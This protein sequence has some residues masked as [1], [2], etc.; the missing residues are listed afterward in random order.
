MS[1]LFEEWF[2]KMFPKKVPQTGLIVKPPTPEDYIAGASPVTGL[3][4][5]RLPNGIWTPYRPTAEAQY[6]QFAF[7]TMACAS[8]SA[9][10]CVEYQI[11]WMIQNGKVSPSLLA[12]LNGNGYLENGVCNL[13]D[14]F[15]AIM[16]GTTKQ[17]NF[18]QAVWDSIRNKGVIPERIFP[19]G[20][21]TWDQYHDATNITEDMKALGLEWVKRFDTVYE[22]V[23][24][25]NNPAFTSDQV[26][27]CKDQLRYAPL[28]IA[29]PVPGTHAITLETIQDPTL[30]VF[31]QYP[32]F[33]NINQIN[34]QIHYAMK[35][36][37]SLKGHLEPVITPVRTLK[38]GLR[39]EDVKTLQRGLKE[40]GWLKGTVDG[41][42]GKITQKAVIAFQKSEN[43]QADGIAGKV[44]QRNLTEALKKKLI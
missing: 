15:T 10:N 22:W 39:G 37:V 24:F 44:T 3:L 12:W 17:G 33:A 2:P 31:D 21:D 16:S 34:Y 20:G 8:F 43:I 23:T 5:E 42:F 27:A 29:V 35:G 6:K 14:R 40:L 32:P 11:N 1:H 13:S 41:D 25:D 4:E 9:N 19:F 28:N 38:I 18:F 30:T 26:S 7:D 36:Y